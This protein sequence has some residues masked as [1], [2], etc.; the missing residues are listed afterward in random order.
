MTFCAKHHTNMQTKKA[1]DIDEYIARY[2]KDVQTILKKIRTTIRKAAPGAEEAISYQMPAFNFRGY[3]IYFA[4]Y[5]NH[6]GIYPVPRDVAEFKEELAQYEGGK[7]TLRLPLDQPI[8]YDL[9]T[10]IVKFR[11]KQNL[12]KAARKA[13]KK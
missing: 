10:R 12:E 8:P 6:I 4:A 11:V 2:P 5:K 3:L 9:I 13:K 1:K 7:G